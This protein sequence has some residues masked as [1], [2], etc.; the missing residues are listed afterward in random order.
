MT[1]CSR[2]RAF[3]LIELLV[4]IAIIGILIALLVPAVQKVRSAAARTQC[5]NG[6]KQIGLA[7]HG[8]HDINGS[9][10][11]ALDNLQ[12]E[13]N[14]PQFGP[15][16]QK[17]WMLSWMAR[18]LNFLE[19]DNLW[20]LTEEEENDTKYGLPSRYDPWNVFD[21][22]TKTSRYVGLAT[23]MKVFSCP[24]DN[25]TLVA[26][27]VAEFGESFIIAFTAYQGVNG[28]S[29]RGG[30]TLPGNV[31]PAVATQNDQVDPTTGLHT[32]MNGI[33]IPVANSG[34]SPPGVRMKQVTD[35]LSNTLMVGERPPSKDL[36]FG[37]W[38]AGFGVSGDGDGDVVL[39]ISETFEN[40]YFPYRDPQ[41][42]P[43]SRGHYNP[44]DPTAY[45]LSPGSI[46]NQCDQFHYWSLHEGGANFLL[47]DGS[48]RFLTYSTSPII[49]RAMAT[50]DGGEVFDAP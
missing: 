13:N 38:F 39:G 27:K 42:R 47:G 43:C 12:W 37:W 49:Q 21:P 48:V 33:L 29:H 36:W 11:P 45:K 31:G 44:N 18:I 2:G 40:S 41:N 9:F 24:A 19:Q 22:H 15:I 16:T 10:P 3:T 14:F 23:E 20:R 1:R 50:R 30:H 28:I 8:Y 17:Y 32:G 6:L 26:S 5:A 46:D 7:L 4:V 34:G 25:R 35:G